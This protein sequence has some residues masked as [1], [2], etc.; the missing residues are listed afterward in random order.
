M[1]MFLAPIYLIAILGTLSLQKV[2]AQSIERKTLLWE[3]K[4]ASLG[5]VLEEKGPAFIEFRAQNPHMEPI[6]ITDVI[7][8][9]G[10]TTVNYSKDTLKKDQNASIRLKFDPDH[11]GGDFLKMV[12]V[13][14]N[15][16][17]YGDTL[18]LEGTNIPLPENPNLDYPNRV[19][20]LGFRLPAV[21]MGNVF[22]NEPKLKYVEIY[23]FGKVPFALQEKQEIPVHMKISMEPLEVLPSQRGLLLLTYEGALKKDLGFFEEYL[24]LKV[25][26]TEE[27]FSVKVLAVVHE[28][29][30][31]VPKSMEKVVPRLGLSEPEINLREISSTQKISRTVQLTNLGRETLIIRKVVSN[32]DCLEL[33]LASN[34]LAEGEKTELKLIFDPKGRKGIDYRTITIFSNDPLVP[35]RNIVIKSSVK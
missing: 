22:T 3:N 7:T 10:C 28:Y 18:F 16:D 8:D 2:S 4:R 26:G 34:S 25:K 9:C 20:N 19:G 32:C 6:F 1:K 15:L 30:A 24:K 29:F 12:V 5:A 13:R 31:P 11:R 21:N 35:I 33:E 14:T 23:N 27:P 17:I